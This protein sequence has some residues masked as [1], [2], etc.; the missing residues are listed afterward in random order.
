MIDNQHL[1]RFIMF[2]LWSEIEPWNS[3]QI[4]VI[5]ISYHSDHCNHRGRWR[6]L[7]M[8]QLRTDLL[9]LLWWHNLD[10]QLYFDES[11]KKLIQSPGQA[12]RSELKIANSSNKLWLSTRLK[13]D[14]VISFIMGF[15]FSFY[16]PLQ[17]N[18]QYLNIFTLGI[19]TYYTKSFLKIPVIINFK[20]VFSF[21]Y[22]KYRN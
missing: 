13:N 5:N 2:H 12:E 9:F 22:F 16:T 7:K 3:S 20:K 4:K 17:C 21:K 6:S 18:I 1:K 19:A 8:Y 10:V 11:N 14:N 15:N